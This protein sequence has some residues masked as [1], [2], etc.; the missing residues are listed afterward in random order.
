MK[1]NIKYYVRESKIINLIFL[2]CFFIYLKKLPISIETQ[3]FIIFFLSIFYLMVKKITVTTKDVL[4]VLHL[5]LLSVYVLFQIIIKKNG[6]IDYFTYLVGP[7]VYFVFLNNSKL[8]SEKIVKWVVILYATVAIVLLLKI[9]IAY[10]LVQNFYELFIPRPG[11]IDGSEIRGVTLF[12]PEPS[13][14][15][16]PSVLLLVALDILHLNGKKNLLKYKLLVIAIIIISK[17]ALVFLYSSIYLLFYYLGNN[18]LR[19]IQIIKSK[20][21]IVFFFFILILL[22]PFFIFENSRLV[23]VLGNI[24]DNV[25]NSENFKNLLLKEVSGS[26]RFIINTLGFL[27][28]EY[29]PFGW[30]IGEFQNNFYV[31]GEQF[32]D[33]MSRHEVIRPLYLNHLPLKAQTYFANLTGDIG[34]FSFPLLGFF[35][36]SFLQKTDDKIKRGLQWVLPL[37]LIFVQAQISNPIPWILL[38][39]INSKDLIL[40]KGKR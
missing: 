17:S 25:S 38:A 3:P 7:A 5:I 31:V 24:Y 1:E 36:W 26:T 18:P 28:I 27:S 39:V 34:V 35:I 14:F 4:L 30:G 8:I 37:M 2:L 13:Y 33:L 9:P 32:D 12:A 21:I 6:L 10:A 40:I 19:R 20:R 23:E 16:F 29:A 11:W 15:A 22:I